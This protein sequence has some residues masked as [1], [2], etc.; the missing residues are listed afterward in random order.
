MHERLEGRAKNRDDLRRVLAS[1][2]FKR[3]TDRTE[4]RQVGDEL[5]LRQR[6]GDVDGSKLDVGPPA[7]LE[8]RVHA[9]SSANANCPGAFGRRGGRFGS[10]G[11]AALSA[12][13][14]NGFDAPL[15][16]AI[17]RSSPP[18]RT[19]CRRFANAATGSSKNIT[20]KREMIRSKR[21]GSKGYTCAL[22]QMNVGRR[23]LPSRARPCCGDQSALRCRRLARRARLPL[24][25]RARLQI[26]V[27]RGFRLM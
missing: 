4:A 26:Y 17:T 12:V 23:V 5:L 15:R 16:Q 27:G 18:S 22:A 21:A 6:A 10:S 11:A 14:M 3:P 19:A 8:D 2:S 9:P 24:V 7:L 1:T 20:P 25:R 13:V